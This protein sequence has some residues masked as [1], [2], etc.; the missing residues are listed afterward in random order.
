MITGS[1]R[2]MSR[3]EMPAHLAIVSTI[4]AKQ[5]RRLAV[6]AN[7]EEGTAIKPQEVS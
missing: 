2:Q 4:S 7:A 6:A 3:A 5:I 1:V